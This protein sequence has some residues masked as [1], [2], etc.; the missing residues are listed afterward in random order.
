MGEGARSRLQAMNPSWGASGVVWPVRP[1]MLCDTDNSPLL[2]GRTEACGRRS[3]TPRGSVGAGLGQTPSACLL[4]LCSRALGS[5]GRDAAELTWT[6][7]AAQV[8]LGSESVSPPD[9]TGLSSYR[10]RVFLSLL[11]WD[12]RW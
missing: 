6:E 2:P 4:P 9:H 8:V 3:L 12:P 11:Q 5:L 10:Q 1:G 7:Q